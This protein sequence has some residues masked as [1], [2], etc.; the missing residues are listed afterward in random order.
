M[1]NKDTVCTWCRGYEC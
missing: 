1:K